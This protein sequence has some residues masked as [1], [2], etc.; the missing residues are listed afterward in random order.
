MPRWR[1]INGKAI[2]CLSYEVPSGERWDD[3]GKGGKGGIFLLVVTLHWWDITTRSARAER[4]LRFCAAARDAA[5]VFHNIRLSV[6]C[7]SAPRHP[8]PSMHLG[9]SASFLR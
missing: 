3:V 7:S 4:R 2:G 8:K 1:A 5:W 9:E 6:E